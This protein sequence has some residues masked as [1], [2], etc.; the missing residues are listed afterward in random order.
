MATWCQTHRQ[1]QYV[2]GQGQT[3][4][5]WDMTVVGDA[6]SSACLYDDASQE[7]DSTRVTASILVGYIMSHIIR[8]TRRSGFFQDSKLGL[9]RAAAPS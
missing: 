2:D 1:T 6:D 7:R 5:G 3:M 9:P 8:C 4:L